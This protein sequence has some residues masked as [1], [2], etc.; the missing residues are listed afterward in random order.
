MSVLSTSVS[1]YEATIHRIVQE[2]PSVVTLYFERPSGFC[3][4][5]GQYITVFFDDTGVNEGKAYSLSS[6]PGDFDLCITVK[7]IGLFSGRLHD[8]KAG[9]TLCIS[10]AYGM[11]NAFRDA[12]LV[13]L[14][15]GVGI[16]PI[17]SIIRHDVFRGSD[18]PIRLVYTN[19]TDDE[20][21]FKK[22]LDQ[23]AHS[24]NGF[25]VTYIVTR[26]DDSEYTGPRMNGADIA[27]DYPDRMVCICGAVDF[28]RD[29]RRQLVEAGIG[30][31]AI[32]TE[33]FFE[34]A[35]VVHE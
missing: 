2:S 8:M 15:A 34:T 27:R 32:M 5:A 9:D 20:M 14:A 6:Q 30:E 11:F 10:P 3:Y 12:P 31:E 7:K 26:Q 29:M 1:R 33:V 13:A 21:V 17:Y 19:T 25:D 23:L 35:G 24:T 22:E 18:R 28:V 16:A 4:T